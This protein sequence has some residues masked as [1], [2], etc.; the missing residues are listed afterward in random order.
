MALPDG[1]LRRQMIPSLAEQGGVTVADL[2]SLWSEAGLMLR[3]ASPESS[4][5]SLSMTAPPVR[6]R[7][8]Y[9]SSRRAARNAPLT[10]AAGAL[11]MLLLNSVWWDRLT[12]DDHDLLNHMPRPEGPVF[13]WLE[14]QIA[15]HGPQSWAVLKQGLIADEMQTSEGELVPESALDDDMSF[16]DLQSTVNLIWLARLE[17]ESRS[18]SAIVASDPSALV[19]F[20]EVDA[21][22][23]ERKE[24]KERLTRQAK[25]EG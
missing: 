18:L 14:R 5:P 9:Q 25:A 19:R 17:E 16:D 20:R 4:D 3:P 15:E 1:A 7:A 23:K 13:A 10:P 21:K 2:K 12:A 22:Y 24:R 8:T 6:G 11:R